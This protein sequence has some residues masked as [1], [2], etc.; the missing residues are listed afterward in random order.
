MK[1]T[2]L[3]LFSAIFVWA[4]TSGPENPADSVYING[5]IYTVDEANPK[6]QAVAAACLGP[7]TT[8]CPASILRTHGSVRLFLD[9]FSALQLTA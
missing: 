5:I 6:A 2:Y 7:L 8:K 1:N 3:L 4:C 9:E